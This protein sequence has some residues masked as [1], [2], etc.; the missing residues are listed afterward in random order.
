MTGLTN[1]I[2]PRG[3]IMKN[4]SNIEIELKRIAAFRK[5]I[6]RTTI[7]HTDALQDYFDCLDIE[8]HRLL[9]AGGIK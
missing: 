7:D 6:A 4:K 1:L 9:K 3:G 2:I 5:L 8:K